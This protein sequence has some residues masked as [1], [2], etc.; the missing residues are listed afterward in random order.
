MVGQATAGHVLVVPGL[1]VDIRVITPAL[2]AGIGINGDSDAVRRADEQ[3]IAH[4]E[5]CDLIGEFARIV[6]PRQVAGV[7]FPGFNQV[8]DVI[9]RDQVSSGIAVALFRSAVRGPFAIRATGLALWVQTLHLRIAELARDRVVILRQRVARHQR[10]G[11]QADPEQPARAISPDQPVADV[12]ID[13]GQDQ[14]EAED[15]PEID[16]RRQLPPVETHLV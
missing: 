8:A 4:L 6:R 11:Q 3:A 9:R 7:V 1:A 5:R 2:F 14:P 13:K 16:P 12:A 10:T 15:A